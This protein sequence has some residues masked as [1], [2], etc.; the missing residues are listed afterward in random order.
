MRCQL[1]RVNYVTSGLL[2]QVE[3]WTDIQAK[4]DGINW[5]GS[6]IFTVSFIFIG[7]FIF[8]N[9]F[10]GLVIMNI[11]E[12]TDEYKVSDCQLYTPPHSPPCVAAYIAD[13]IGK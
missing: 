2:L 9:V 3:S 1:K 7:H 10:I 8:T 5:I 11:N 4:L 13:P 12:A 6:K